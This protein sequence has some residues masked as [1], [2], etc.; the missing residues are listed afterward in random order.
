[1]NLLILLNAPHYLRPFVDTVR[2]LAGR[3]HRI[4]IAW[5]AGPDR[6][7]DSIVE[8][9]ADLPAVRFTTVPSERSVRGTEVGLVRR[10]RNYLRYLEDPFR[11]SAKLR[12]RSF[13]KLVRLVT[14]NAGADG[15]GGEV[16]LGLT[17]EEVRR[18]KKALAY[19]ESLIPLDPALSVTSLTSFENDR[20][21]SLAELRNGSS[22]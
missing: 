17:Q 11:S 19:L 20:C 7:G 5:Y 10:S 6:T 12:Q 8:R 3:G 9:F 1:M 21:L 14:D 13:S 2:T 18:L 16:G 22:R 4:T 15:S